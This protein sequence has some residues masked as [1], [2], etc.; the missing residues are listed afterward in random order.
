MLRMARRSEAAAAWNPSPAPARVLQFE[1]RRRDAAGWCVVRFVAAARGVSTRHLL[2]PNRGEAD[3]ALAR[4]LAMYL[5][6]V[7]LGRHYLDVGR[8]GDD[9]GDDVRRG[10]GHKAAPQS[11]G[12]PAD[13]D[14]TDAAH[15]IQG[16]FAWIWR[17]GGYSFRL[18]GEIFGVEIRGNRCHDGAGGA[19]LLHA[20]LP[21][22]VV[23]EGSEPLSLV[24]GMAGPLFC[25]RRQKAEP[26]LVL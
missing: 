15:R 7:V 24:Q 17:V 11:P 1:Q 26:G 19:R 20:L 10:G 14:E 21:F 12:Q 9:R 2:M 8:F 6:H 5:M 18:H 22:F 3:I 23:E 13:R 16:A 25:L 4:Q